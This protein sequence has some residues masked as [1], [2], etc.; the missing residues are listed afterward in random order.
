MKNILKKLIESI[1]KSNKES[2]DSKRLDCCDLNKK[3]N[4]GGKKNG[5]S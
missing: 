5:K 3:N 4:N 2:F 1:A